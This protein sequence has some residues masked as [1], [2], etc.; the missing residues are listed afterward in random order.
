MKPHFD[1]NKKLQLDA[2]ASVTLPPNYQT[3]KTSII[4]LYA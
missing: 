1:P 3:I 2:V 4:V